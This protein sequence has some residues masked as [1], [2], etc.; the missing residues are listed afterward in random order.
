[1]DTQL[2]NSGQELPQATLGRPP[3]MVV[4]H[5]GV[6]RGSACSLPAPSWLLELQ[7]SQLIVYLHS[8][9]RK[10]EAHKGRDWPKVTYPVCFCF[11][12]VVSL[13]LSHPSLITPSRRIAEPKW[14]PELSAS[15]LCPPTPTPKFHFLEKAERT[16]PGSAGACWRGGGQGEGEGCRHALGL[17]TA[18]GRVRLESEGGNQQAQVSSGRRGDLVGVK[19]KWEKSEGPRCA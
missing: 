14:P 3:Q 9:D 6:P 7:G 16:Q 19:V 18:S 5:L 2:G 11:L 12:E 4:I 17:E 1:M 15:S 10:T 8:I 13:P